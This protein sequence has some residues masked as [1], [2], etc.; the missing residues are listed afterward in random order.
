MN[1]RLFLLTLL[2]S[3]VATVVAQ[4]V[5]TLKNGDEI[6]GKVTKVT[7]TEIEY[8]LATNPDGPTYTK[9]V[10]EIFMVKY[11]NGQKDVFNNTPEPAKQ[12]QQV[13]VDIPSGVTLE[14]SRGE[15]VDAATDRT[16]SEFELQQMLGM[17]AFNDYVKARDS[18]KS[19]SNSLVWAYL[20]FFLG[21]PMYIG[22]VFLEDGSNNGLAM[23]IIGI[24]WT[25]GGNI[26]IP[27]SYITRGVAAGKISRIAEG[28]NAKNGSLGME[29]SGGFTLMPTAQGTVAPGLGISLRF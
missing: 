25:I 24:A 2:L 7:S 29:I 12:Q 9:A 20:F 27:A 5:I 22:G 19:T 21:P 26:M 6:N 8:K 16:F 1:K 4:D 28:Y 15:I 10:S 13:T 17:D 14:R 11:E 23:R 3:F 18:Y